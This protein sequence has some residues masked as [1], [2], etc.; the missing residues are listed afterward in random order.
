MIDRDDSTHGTVRLFPLGGVV[1]FP[2]SMIP[3]HI[4]EPRYRQMTEDA[5]EDDRRI[6]LILPRAI[7][8]LEKELVQIG[9]QP[10][11][12]EVG[13]VGSIQHEN[14]LP[15]GRLTFILQ[16]QQRFRIMRELE[17]DRL[18]RSAHVRFL[19]DGLLS[20]FVARRQLQRIEILELVTRLLP[21]S[22]LNSEQFLNFLKDRCPDAVF[23]D[24]LAYASPL[25]VEKK[26]ELLEIDGVDS[27]LEFL[28]QELK[29]SLSEAP[30]QRSVEFPPSF[31]NN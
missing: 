12:H 16:G 19:Q 7:S 15:D 27:R 28:L 29:S 11:I 1:L 17:T 18:Y 26:Q 10:P 13:C 20:E 14:R 30:R 24:T 4:F 22:D 2:H 31:S 9:I 3:L 6:A 8:S 5:L 25:S 21:R 23:V